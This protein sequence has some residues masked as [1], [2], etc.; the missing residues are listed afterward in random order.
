MHDPQADGPSS[1]KMHYYAPIPDQSGPWLTK[2]AQQIYERSR[3]DDRSL[4]RRA[5]VT[6]LL[7]RH[8][9]DSSL[10]HDICE[11]SQIVEPYE[12]HDIARWPPRFVLIIANDAHG[13]VVAL[14]RQAVDYGKDPPG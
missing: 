3:I 13:F 12:A 4:A 7:F 11:N 5:R 9:A 1:R 14:K 10:V 6:K 2:E 8:P